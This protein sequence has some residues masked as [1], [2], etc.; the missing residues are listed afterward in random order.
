MTLSFCPLQ[1]TPW[2]TVPENYDHKGPSDQS[3]L[4]L[5]QFGSSGFTISMALCT[6]SASPRILGKF[7]SP[8]WV[9]EYHLLPGVTWDK[10]ESLAFHCPHTVLLCLFILS[11]FVQIRWCRPDP[12]LLS[13]CF[14]ESLGS[15]GG[16]SRGNRGLF[17]KKRR[18]GREL[19]MP[20]A[21][22]GS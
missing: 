13:L 10:G 22:D 9:I 7:P 15:T 18:A 6:H 1:F 2:R 8:H 11:V 3:A 19:G 17:F 12:W 14:L 5:T 21:Q 4:N 16:P 20:E